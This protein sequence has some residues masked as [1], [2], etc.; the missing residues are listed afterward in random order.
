MT[1]EFTSESAAEAGRRSGESRRRKAALSPEERAREAIGD[2]LAT[3]V[4][5]LIDAGLGKGDFEDLPLTVRVNAL[6][7][8]IE[9]GIG[10]P[11]PGTKAPQTT[12][13]SPIP[14]GDALFK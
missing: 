3:L 8:L 9:W 2:K 1:N 12:E 4:D 7:K 14:E 11:P 13:E 10:R 5:E 6:T